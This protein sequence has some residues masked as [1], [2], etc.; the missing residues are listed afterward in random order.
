VQPPP[1]GDGENHSVWHWIRG[2]DYAARV[3]LLW[4]EYCLL[5]LSQQSSSTLYRGIPQRVHSESE[6]PEG[7]SDGLLEERDGNLSRGL[8][9]IDLLE[10]IQ[11]TMQRDGSED[12]DLTGPLTQVVDLPEQAVI[13]SPASPPKRRLRIGT[14]PLA[15]KPNSDCNPCAQTMTHGNNSV[16]HHVGY[17]DEVQECDRLLL[18]CLLAVLLIVSDLFALLASLP[19]SVRT[20]PEDYVHVTDVTVR[21]V[22]YTL[23]EAY[24]N[25]D[26]DVPVALCSVAVRIC[27]I[28]S[29][30]QQRFD[31]FREIHVVSL[32]K[33]LLS[34]VFMSEGH[35]DL[36]SSVVVLSRAL[37]DLLQSESETPLQLESL[38]HSTL[39]LLECVPVSVT[40]RASEDCHELKYGVTQDMLLRILCRSAPTALI[41]HLRTLLL[42]NLF[43]K[44]REDGLNVGNGSEFSLT[45]QRTA[46]ETHSSGA[47]GK[48]TGN[49]PP[50]LIFKLLLT[51][52]TIVVQENEQSREIVTD[53]MDDLLDVLRTSTCRCD[54]KTGQESSGAPPGIFDGYDNISRMN[55]VDILHLMKY[56]ETYL[57]SY[58][59]SIG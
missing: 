37:V 26:D 20:V 45:T 31:A 16:Q 22:Q 27:C 56:F 54:D 1:S 12:P 29:S 46:M 24:A 15:I 41:V 25:T 48:G 44:G 50:D 43:G 35:E 33:K 28:V 23:I 21:W 55:S 14:T 51:V 18:D 39:L 40:I 57:R 13:L 4:A 10:W 3:T 9:F 7:K 49:I 2:G 17:A 59:S 8:H 47:G 6:A 52:C 5:E 58:R 30:L 32:L 36:S 38:A 34:Q 53:V 19:S 11:Y 42:E